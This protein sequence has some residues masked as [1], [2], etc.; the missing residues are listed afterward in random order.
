MTP[1]ESRLE[2]LLRRFVEK[3][4]ACKGTGRRRLMA[5]CDRTGPFPY[6]DPIPCE[7][8]TDAREELGLQPMTPAERS[9]AK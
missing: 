8:C 4:P 5:D 9:E 6:G 1:R 3:C 2:E 7:L